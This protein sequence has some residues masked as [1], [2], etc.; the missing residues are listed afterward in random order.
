MN[1]LLYESQQ[2]YLVKVAERMGRNDRWPGPLVSDFSFRPAACE[3]RMLTMGN[4]DLRIV[5]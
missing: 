5:S 1:E 4:T 3:G 2:V